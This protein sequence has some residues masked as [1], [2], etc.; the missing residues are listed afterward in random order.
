MANQ[1]RNRL[2][3]LALALCLA[4]GMLLPAG[5]VNAEGRSAGILTEVTGQEREQLA[6]LA[7]DTLALEEPTE[8]SPAA[9]TPV[10]VFIVLSG[11]SALEQ[12]YAASAMAEA[13]AYTGRLLNRQAAVIESIETQVLKEPLEVR[14]Q[15]T[16]VANAISAVV[17]YGS[18]EEIATLPG[19]EQ[20]CPVPVYETCQT[21]LSPMTITTG[22]MV[23]SYG[24]WENGYTGAGMRIAVI[25]TGLDLDHPSFDP[26]AYD[27]ALGQEQGSWDLLDQEEIA[28]VLPRLT[29]AQD[30]LT[31]AD[32]YRNTKVAFGYNYVDGDL[33]ITHDHDSAGDHGTHVSGIATANRYVPKDGGFASAAETVLA[34]GVAPEAQLLVMKVFGKNGGAYAD[35]YMA[36]IQDAISLGCD[37]INLSL[38]SNS[39]G[40][41]DPAGS[42]VAYAERLFQSLTQTDTVVTISAGN[43]YSAGFQSATGTDLHRTSDPDVDTVGS[44]GSY[45]NALTVASVTNSGLTGPYLSMGQIN[46]SSTAVG[47]APSGLESWESLDADGEGTEYPFVFL[48]DPTSDTDTRKYAMSQ[49]DFNG[50][51]VTGKIVLV[52]RGTNAFSEKHSFAAQAGARAVIVYNNTSGT[53]NMDLSASTGTIPCVFLTQKDMQRILAASEQGADGSWGGV[54]T[55]HSAPAV[56]E[57]AE[58]G[59]RMS[60]FSSWGVPGDL[61][62]KP[63]ITA[64]GGNIYST[65]DGGAYGAMSGTSMAAP[66]M[67]GLSAL[68]LQY[69]DDQNLTERT[70]LSARALAQ[71]LLMSTAKPLTEESGLPY[72]PRKQGAGLANAQKATTAQ[73]YLLT[74]AASGN[75]GKVKVELG[76]DPDRTGSYQFTFTVYNLS[77]EP[78][79]YAFGSDVL[80]EAVE[81]LDGVD[82]MAETSHGLSPKVDFA[83]ASMPYDLT[84]D[85]R[86]DR[87]DAMAFLRHC[88]G[89]L[90][91][92]EQKL[93]ILDLDGDGA[94]TTGDAQRYLCQLEDLEGAVM[95]DTGCTVAPGGSAT[96]TVTMDLSKSDR[97]YLD[98]N[99]EN[100]IYVD[101][102]VYVRE[103]ERS[104]EEGVILENADL[105]LPFLAYYGSWS[106][107]PMLEDAWYYDEATLEHSYSG[108]FNAAV[109]RVDGQAFGLGLNPFTAEASDYLA[110]RNA[111]SPNGDGMADCL[112]A[113]QISLLRNAAE[114]SVRIESE[115]GK[116]VYYE[117]ILENLNR[118]YYHANT[119]AW[120]NTIRSISLGWAGTDDHGAVLPD[121]TK[122]V[123][124]I[125]AKP[126]SG[127]EGQTWRVP[128]TVDCAA[129][130][131]D[132]DGVVLDS[133]ARTLTVTVSDNQYLA[134]AVLLDSAGLSILQRLQVDDRKPGTG[135][136]L[137]W[138]L[139]DV[140]TTFCYLAVSDYAMNTAIYKI[141][142]SSF[143]PDFEPSTFYGYNIYMEGQGTSGWVSFTEESAEQPTLMTATEQPYYAAEYV[144]G[145]VYAV[146][147]DELQVMRPGEYV[148]TKIGDIKLSESS[149]YFELSGPITTVL[150]MAYDYSTDTMY[151]IGSTMVDLHYSYVFLYTVDLD[152]AEFTQ[153]GDS[154]IT[155]RTLKGVATLACDL[156]GTLYCVERGSQLAKLYKL[157]VQ[158]DRVTCESIG[159]DTGLPSSG[160]IQTMTFDHNTGNLYWANCFVYT[161]TESQS[162]YNHNLIQ[163][164]L[165]TG[166]GTVLGPIGG[167]ETCGLYVPYDREIAKKQVERITLVETGWQYE[168]QTQQLQAAVFPVTAEDQRLTWSSSNEKVASV[169][170]NGVVTAKEAGKTTI[171]VTSVAS[172]EISASCEFTVKPFDGKD[173]RGY[174]A[175]AGNG[176]PGWIQFH[177]AAPEEFTIL[178]ETPGLH[179]TGADFGKSVVYASGYTDDDRTEALFC[180]DPDTLEVQERINVSMPFADITYASG[181]NMIFFVYQTYFGFVPLTDLTL[182]ENTY[183]AGM[184][185]Y[186]DLSSLIGNDYLTGV[187]DRLY[188]DDYSSFTAITASGLSYSLTVSP[189][190]RLMASSGIDL[191]VEAFSEQ[192]NSLIYSHSADTGNAVYYYSV[193]SQTRQE[194]TLYAITG[195][196]DG[197]TQVLTL[198]S[199]GEGKAPLTGTFIDYLAEAGIHSAEVPEML[200]GEPLLTLEPSEL[201][202][203]QPPVSQDAQP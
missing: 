170:E 13:T 77:Q 19:V 128:I 185:L 188:D 109:T 203:Y 160:Y 15:F 57:N 74:G 101:G 153:V 102:F 36:A 104:T 40:F 55:L 163:L 21:E 25:D 38:G 75:D 171:T 34:C 10:R 53:V 93:A 94:V 69:I 31:A 26:A 197:K 165:E 103:V 159:D 67:A 82:Y 192:G 151:A 29:I 168:G 182:G 130:K 56:L 200:E 61:S 100:G 152:T 12:G 156:D 54:M 92:P 44:P 135:C 189:D 105:S 81:T 83:V 172:P 45:E 136:K 52:S 117:E 140:R 63:E 5:Q 50:L 58:D 32:L 85:N 181:H 3:A 51:D 124:A 88:N 126:G 70:G 129:P 202:V 7:D 71:A 127:E 114:F 33:D 16:A 89:S 84:G 125:T 91:L 17:P 164:D 149:T 121:G 179:I 187:A 133:A 196:M 48:G 68:V 150:D 59:Y 122:A 112:A 80:T 161:A 166:K 14:Y 137:T 37:A 146:T 24:T 180:L 9:D 30:G 60:D 199:F 148:P 201:Q 79:T 118:A 11:K 106:E 119:G 87:E 115:D 18:M 65:L 167:I 120:Q 98:G 1:K 175:D 41:V 142:L 23:G 78:K 158:D 145:C 6:S 4:L 90:T 35:D 28:Q 178:R 177:A 191:E 184:A 64:P 27:Y 47:S 99:F 157:K 95:E 198:G 2:L 39:P 62:L 113:L 154:Y 22:D 86:V 46:A 162:F 123:V 66:A 42:G 110:D 8:A 173:M 96:V 20:V 73:S 190:F 131:A 139:Q 43:A 174:L 141:D 108:G 193:Q 143:N 155:S 72:S 76:D 169:D 176:V 147:Q 107:P 138:D 186:F 132:L 183:S 195:D 97:A 194:T 134:D 144:D 111:I 116:Q 49:S